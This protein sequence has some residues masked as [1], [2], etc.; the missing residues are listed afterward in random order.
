M[1]LQLAAF[2]S[3]NRIFEICRG[4]KAVLLDHET[5]DI[6]SIAMTRSELLAHDAIIVDQLSERVRLPPD[7]EIRAL[8]CVCILRPERDNIT[9]LE[10]ELTS[11]HFARYD[12]FF[13][14]V[15]PDAVLRAIA[16]WDT[17][18]LVGYVH[19]LYLDYLPLNGRL[20]SLNLPR[21]TDL[22]RDSL[23]RSPNGGKAARVAGGV[24]SA[25]CS[26]RVRPVIRFDA[27]SPTAKLVANQLAS[28]VSESADLFST[29]TDPE[30]VILLLDRRTDPVT[31]LLHLFYFASCVHDLLG[32]AKNVVDLRNGQERIIDERNDPAS[33]AINLMYMSDAGEKIAARNDENKRQRLRVSEARTVKELSANMR[34]AQ[35]I[36][37]ETPYIATGVCLFQAVSRAVA[38]QNLFDV[39][40]SEQ[41]LVTNNACAAHCEQVCRMIASPDCSPECAL[42]MAMLF[43]LHYERDG[44]REIERV[45]EALLWKTAWR[46]DEP[47]YVR[48]LLQIAGQSKR[49]SESDIFSNKSIIAKFIGGLTSLQG[50]KSKFEMYHA[51][52]EKILLKLKEQKLPEAAFPFAPI[53]KKGYPGKVIV[54]YVGG[55]TYEEMR[56]A[57]LVSGNPEKFDVVVGGTTVHNARS[58]IECE[59]APYADLA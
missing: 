51:P 58:F 2:R 21:L 57:S 11:P 35:A 25:I 28:L 9:L 23:T 49:G 12:L 43:A 37:A 39:A 52:L 53:E 42:R 41:V 24:F 8:N 15:I 17:H 7:P 31:P 26:L 29:P 55:V 3:L 38:D 33:A 19:E 47:S 6:V 4:T 14:N 18:Q 59:I 20:F 46:N 50:N 44:P 34:L 32:I 30:A 27:A 16:G 36:Q 45:M 13:T 54:F 56:I 1:N 5:I 40:A 48:V 22:R 10:R